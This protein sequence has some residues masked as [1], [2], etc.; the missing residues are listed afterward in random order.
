MRRAN[1]VLQWVWTEGSD[2]V[3]Q[4][5]RRK[6]LKVRTGGCKYHHEVGMGSNRRLE[7][8]GERE[9]EHWTYRPSETKS[10]S[11]TKRCV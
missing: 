4:S 2:D 9:T 7:R 11:V 3:N 5:V 8:C 10:S 6:K 1:S